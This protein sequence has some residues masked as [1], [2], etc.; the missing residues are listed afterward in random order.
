L[1]DADYLG[2]FPAQ[3]ARREAA[4]GAIVILPVTLRAT[5]M[6]MGITT[7]TNARLSPAAEVLV[8]TLRRTA[9][10]LARHDV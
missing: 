6:P 2:V 9:A 1:I 4:A 5:A 10:D 8:E 7:R 3:V